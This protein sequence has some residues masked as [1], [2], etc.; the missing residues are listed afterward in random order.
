MTW[1]GLTVLDRT[2][3]TS[4]IPL[5]TQ[6][7]TKIHTFKHDFKTNPAAFSTQKRE[8]NAHTQEKY[9]HVLNKQTHLSKISSSPDC[10]RPNSTALFGHVKG[11]RREAK[12]SEALVWPV[13]SLHPLH[14][15]EEPSEEVE[16]AFIQNKKTTKSGVVKR[17]AGLRPRQRTRE[18]SP[19]LKKVTT[20]SRFPE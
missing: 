7:H 9:T 1:G 14:L 4:N 5:H 15:Q 6:T 20:Q 8:F 17:T 18:L 2:S 19:R 13:F 3:I 11:V 10:F 12:A 16:P